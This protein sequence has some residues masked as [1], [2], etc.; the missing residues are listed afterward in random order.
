MNGK[1]Q[2]RTRGRKVEREPRAGELH[3]S[4]SLYLCLND[5]LLVAR[6]CLTFNISLSGKRDSRES[7]E[8][9]DKQGE[10]ETDG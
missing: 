4:L 9:R 10:G 8:V 1:R 7:G 6:S 3:F 2:R 5:S